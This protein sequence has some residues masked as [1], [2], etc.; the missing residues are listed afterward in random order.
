MLYALLGALVWITA[1]QGPLGE[2]RRQQ[3]AGV[4]TGHLDPNGHCPFLPPWGRGGCVQPIA[5]LRESLAASAEASQ[6]Q[7]GGE[8]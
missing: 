3:E 1:A 5:N 8:V 7:S 6:C 4:M 2:P